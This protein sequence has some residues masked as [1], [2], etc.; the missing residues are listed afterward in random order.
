MTFK[1]V[2]NWLYLTESFVATAAYGAVALL[3]MSDVIGRELFS[4]SLFGAQ[5]VAVYGAIVA[6]FLGLTLATSDN[7]HLRPEFM[8]NVFPHRLHHRV[9]AI[10][11]GISSVFFVGACIISIYFVNETRIAGDKAAVLYFALWPIQVVIPYAFLSTAF[12][13][14]IFAIKPELK[15]KSDRTREP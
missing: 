9:A 4:S 15:P 3:L 7:A 5:Q 14:L 1:R 2:L 8:D 10:G 13:H 11:D 12:K 6:G